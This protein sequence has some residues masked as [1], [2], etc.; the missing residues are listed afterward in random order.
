MPASDAVKTTI[1]PDLENERRTCTFDVEELARYWIGD[2][3]K[4]DDKRARGNFGVFF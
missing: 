2:Q 3:N 4:L 1:N